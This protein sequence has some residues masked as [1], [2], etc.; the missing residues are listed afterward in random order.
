LDVVAAA[1][2]DALSR[3]A[4]ATAA[5]ASADYQILDRQSGL[6][7][8]AVAAAARDSIHDAQDGT[9]PGGHST[10]FARPPA[11]L[12]TALPEPGSSP[13]TRSGRPEHDQ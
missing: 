12:P 7:V 11:A 1:S 3:H 10:A 9:R 8:A 5:G 4:A 2:A 13:V 6:T